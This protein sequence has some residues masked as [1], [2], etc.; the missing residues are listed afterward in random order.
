MFLERKAG[1]S[2]LSTPTISVDEC[3]SMFRN[4]ERMVEILQAEVV[5]AIIN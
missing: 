4:T 3:I 2:N 1:S 5:T